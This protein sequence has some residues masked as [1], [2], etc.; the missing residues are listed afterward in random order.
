MVLIKIAKEYER[1]VI[2][3]LGRLAGTRGPGLFIVIPG[4]EEAVI[5]DLR[6]VTL[7]V[8]PQDIITEDNVPVKVNAVIYF[9]IVDPERSVIE[10]KDYMLATSQISQT[11]LRS[12]LGRVEL[13]E[14]LSHR[15][16][17]NE[18]LQLIIDKATDPWGI[19]V[20][21]VEIKDVEIP[22]SMKRAIAK[23]AEAERERRARVILSK[24]EYEAAEKLRDAGD[25]LGADP[26]SLRYLE[27]ITDV[28]KEHNTTILFP[29]EMIKFLKKEKD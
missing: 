9:R 17:L 22:E 10:I 14:L 19:K 20:T 13:D 18:E 12:T 4:M 1:G 11:S 26:I 27:A 23:Q 6:V 21:A 28:S 15:E 24:G 16:K 3:R 25:L 2:F 8:P 5:I 29:V 7:D